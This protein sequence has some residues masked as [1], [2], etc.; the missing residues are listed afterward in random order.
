MESITYMQEVSNLSGLQLTTHGV[1]CN[2]CPLA[3]TYRD[4]V[5][6]TAIRLAYITDRQARIHQLAVCVDEALFQG[7][8][9][10]YAGQHAVEL[11]QVGRHVFMVPTRMEVALE[12]SVFQQSRNSAGQQFN[13]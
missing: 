4:D 10:D 6:D 8:A 13:I 7:E 3:S 9:V 1:T 5:I 12:Q 11:R 2:L